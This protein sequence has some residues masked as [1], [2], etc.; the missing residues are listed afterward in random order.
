MNFGKLG[1]ACANEK[2]T[3]SR[4]GGGKFKRARQH[5]ITRYAT[6]EETYRLQISRCEPSSCLQNLAHFRRGQVAHQKETGSATNETIVDF[7]TGNL[8]IFSGVRIAH[9][10]ARITPIP[11]AAPLI[12]AMTGCPFENGDAT[13]L[14]KP[15]KENAPKLREHPWRQP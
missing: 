4:D 8:R 14:P 11:I 9:K 3:I 7:R 13:P 6:V 15:C 5:S 12:I 1:L 10:P 2:K